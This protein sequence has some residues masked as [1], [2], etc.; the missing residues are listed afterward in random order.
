MKWKDMPCFW[1]GRI[2][3]VKMARLAKAIYIFNVISIKLPMI[4]S[5][6]LEHN[7]KLIWNRKDPKPQNQSKE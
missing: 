5:T 3:I 1:I 4:F 2:N 7:P 6:E